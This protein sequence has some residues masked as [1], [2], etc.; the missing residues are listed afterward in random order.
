VHAQ[1]SL[2]GQWSLHHRARP[3]RMARSAWAQDV[4]PMW[5]RRV[6]DD[7][8]VPMTEDKPDTLRTDDDQEA[9]P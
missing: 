7:R 3:V 8:E 5:S 6:H 4:P 2:A 1:T 9:T